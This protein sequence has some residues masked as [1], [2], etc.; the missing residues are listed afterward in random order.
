MLRA[1]S[2]KN[3]EKVFSTMIDITK[4]IFGD[5]EVKSMMKDKDEQGR[6]LR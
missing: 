4:E 2:N 3:H 1:A 5:D 6:S